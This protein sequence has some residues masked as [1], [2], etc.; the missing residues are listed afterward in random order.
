VG[1]KENTEIEMNRT[2]SSPLPN[3][4][5]KNQYFV[6]NSV[7]F[8]QQPENAILPRKLSVNNDK[9]DPRETKSIL[10]Q[11]NDYKKKKSVEQSLKDMEDTLIRD[12]IR[13]KKLVVTIQ[14]TS[15]NTSTITPPT[16]SL[17]NVKNSQISLQNNDPYR[18]LL[19]EV[20]SFLGFLIFLIES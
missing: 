20:N 10:D 3:S 2:I 9:L 7:D 14:N 5:Y 11:L 17:I 16:S 19:S 1:Y 18:E 6:Q 8:D 13:D 12:T 15:F 4:N